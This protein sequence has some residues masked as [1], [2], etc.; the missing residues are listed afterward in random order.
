MRALLIVLTIVLLAPSVSRAQAP[1]AHAATARALFQEGVALARQGEYRD[2]IDHFRRSHALHPAT[3]VA[4]NLASALVHAGELVEASE[5]LAQLLRDPTITS[6]L[7]TAADR[8]RVEI[9][10]RLARLTVRLSGDASGVL[11]ELDGEELPG[12]AIGVPV[13]LDPGPHDVRAVR[14]DE[15]AQR[16]RFELSEGERREVVL[17]IAPR[18]IAEAPVAAPPPPVEAVFPSAR[19]D[20]EDPVAAPS[21][22][23][24]VWIGVGI[25]VAVLA[26]GAIAT[27]VVLV[28]MPAGPTPVTGNAMP[29]VLTW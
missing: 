14:D 2:A 5:I 11:V 15:E 18:P 28:T 26:A 24:G 29:G 20:A 8:L 25:G 9:A 4:F 16:E 21:S 27:T 23:D 1:D 10:P 3:P 17:T 7:R 13:P 22:D 19:R 6:V 12:A